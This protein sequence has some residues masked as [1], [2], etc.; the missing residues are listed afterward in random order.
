MRIG[1]GV[2][3][4]AIKAVEP[5]RL[6]EEYAV[7]AVNCDLRTGAI[8]P[9]RGVAN[10]LSAPST[11]ERIYLWQDKVAC[12]TQKDVS[13]LPHPN[14][15]NIIW[16]GTDYGAYPLQASIAQFFGPTATI[17]LP[18]TS[19]RLGVDA[20]SAA[21]VVTV[22]GTATEDADL[23]RSTSYRISAVA[24]TGEES[25]L[26]LPS[27]VVDVYEGQEAQITQFWAGSV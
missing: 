26:S 27:A 23:I 21:P 16:A 13:I 12:F 18:S 7:E 2:F 25:D 24:T 8:V 1:T 3:R 10:T 15:D 6:G 17:S 9:M 11:T 4:G 5:N 20:P 19:S 14:S 22:S